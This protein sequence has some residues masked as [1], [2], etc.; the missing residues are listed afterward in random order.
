[1]KL[2]MFGFGSPSRK[3]PIRRQ[4]RPALSLESLETREVP[5]ATPYVVPT[6]PAV[7]T[8]AIATVG[9]SFGGYKM[10]GIPDG[11]GAFDNGDGTFTVVLNH[12]ISPP[13]GIA[14]AHG[15][16]GAF[17]SEWVI[18]KSDLAVL[19]ARDFI[20]DTSSIYLSNNVPGTAATGVPHSAYFPGSTTIITRLCSGDMAA[21]SAYIWLDPDTNTLYGTD[22]RI[23]MSG[24]ESSGTLTAPAGTPEATI[25][26]GRQFAWIATD[27]SSIAGNQANTGYEIPHCGIFAWENFVASPQA[28]R[29]TIVI[30]SDDTSPAGQLYV[31]V[32]D[33][34]T[35]GNVVERAGLTRQS[36]NDNLFVVK[37]TGLGT[38]ASGATI[39]TAGTPASGAFTLELEGDVS[40][41]TGGALETLSNN[42][43]GT[44]F[45]R[46]E[47][48][49][50]DPNNPSDYYFV[51]THQYDQV[52]DG[53]G[54][55][56]GR[57][58]LYRL[59]FTD[60]AH[61]ELG[62][63]ITC[64]LDGTEAGN[65]FDNIT[66]D[67][68]S[69]VLLQEDVGGQAH[70]GKVWLYD[71]AT[72]RLSQVARHDPARFG[73]IGRAATSPFN[74]DE[75]SSGI[76]DVSDILGPG[77]YLLDVQA[78]YSIAGELVEGGQLLKMT[79]PTPDWAHA[80]SAATVYRTNATGNVL[81]NDA[82]SPATVISHTNPANGSLTI[83][84]DGSYSYTPNAGFIGQDS[85]SYTA[86]A[87][88]VYKTNLPPLGTFGGVDV[89]AGAF[90]SAVS[91]VPGTTDEVYGLTDRGPNVDGPGGSKVE[92]IPTFNPAI[93]RFKLVN[94]QAILLE[95]IALKGPGGEPYNG[96]AISGLGST[97]EVITDL[98]GNV[99]PASP[100]GYDPEGIVAL[101]D[102]TFWVSD[103]YGPFITRF[104]HD[105]TQLQRLAPGAGLPAELALRRVNRG[106]EGLTITPDGTTLVGMMQSPLMNGITTNG[107]NNKTT[108]VRIVTYKLATGEMHEYLYLLDNPATTATAVS[109]IMA[110]TNTTFVVLE[111]DG[112]YTPGGYKKLFTIDLAGAT[113]VGPS[114][115]LINGTT[116]TYDPVKGMV[117]STPAAGTTIELLV[118]N[119]NTGTAANTL[120]AKGVIAVGKT[121]LL[122]LSG[123]IKSIDP[124]GAFFS[125]DKIEGLAL[126]NGKL[127]ISNDSD[128]GID[129][130]T[131]S[132][133][134]FQLHAKTSP[135]TGEVDNGEF[136]LID[137]G[138]LASTLSS[139][140]VTIDVAKATPTITVVDAGGVFN[141]L[142]F[143]ATD[144]TV[145]GVPADGVIA[146]FG[147]PLLS[148]TYYHYGVPLAGAPSAAGEYTVVANYSGND[149]YLPAHSA[150]VAFNIVYS[151]QSF[152]NKNTVNSGSTLP[153]EV[154]VKDANGN[155]IGSSGLPVK[156][157]GLIGP[158]GASYAVDDAGNSNPNGLFR[159]EGGKY[160]FNLKTSK[161]MPAG[162]YTFSYTVG[163]DPTIYT[164]TF[165]V[166]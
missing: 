81:T 5:T 139:T 117:F 71:I 75:E 26:V 6:D 134:P 137:L 36:A 25:T 54:T 141:G 155:N 39:E 97:N 131:N 64:L 83:N 4:P 166:K 18:R 84:A 63:T 87:V 114:S 107:D 48:G 89:G 32:G 123:M 62:G 145:T 8:T 38:E 128:F 22:A 165:D 129:G 93:G 102:G 80:D 12:E 45:L 125:H 116:V 40:G 27:D 88:E 157:L 142:P 66:V 70:N 126:F 160:K 100:F 29:K 15:A 140:T 78:H 136:L 108:P 143:P 122:D 17:V 152:I 34:Q 85:F 3:K 42:K 69:R 110:L 135:V 148:Y 163:D 16:N 30:G 35:T 1:M 76:I 47:D 111:R 23:F 151:V 21:P 105:G 164:L 119:Q 55:T 95:T 106:M 79:V 33:K 14:R 104:A 7:T 101:A 57:T 158:G 154:T 120:S 2:R 138:H 161:S 132:T 68:Y 159:F 133:P 53:I 91:P 52:K 82:A 31:W 43:G 149:Y 121:L 24:E 147:S 50:W 103:E 94:G 46:P 28:Q 150:P 73:E 37:V 60:I 72:D 49:S 144:A 51:T 92:A 124:T 59:H 58:R 9:D 112:L 67:K 153:I 65:M 20:G 44:K 146:T 41:L 96:Q 98:D 10:A 56:V 61:P 127:I 109:E 156:A 99:L 11:M 113:D 86:A 13:S 118:R 90:G 162:T 19:S 115:P 74:N 130:I 77:S